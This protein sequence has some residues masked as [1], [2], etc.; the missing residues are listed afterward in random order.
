M[1][2]YV[3]GWVV[4]A[5]FGL[6]EISCI[7]VGTSA[8]GFGS[9]L[10]IGTF[11]AGERHHFSMRRRVCAG[12]AGIMM[13]IFTSPPELMSHHRAST[14]KRAS[15][16][17]S[18]DSN[19]MVGQPHIGREM[20]LKAVSASLEEPG[21]ENVVPPTSFNLFSRGIP[22]RVSSICISSARVRCAD[23]CFSDGISLII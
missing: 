10:V 17:E 2:V 20:G 19:T 15:P 14:L 1:T 4:S 3:P 7:F 16:S 12:F 13:T 22:H 9:A 18:P 6:I 11:V 21:P 8:L 5:G 23:S